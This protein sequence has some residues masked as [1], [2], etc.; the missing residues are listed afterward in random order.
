MPREFFEQ[1]TVTVARKLLGAYLVHDSPE[2]KTAGRIVETEAYLRNDPACHASKGRTPRNAPM[3]GKPG[4]AYV[5]LIYGMYHCFNVVSAPEGIGEAVLIRAL[6][7][8]E[9]L[10]LMAERRGCAVGRN[11]CGGPGRLAQAMDLTPVC[12]GESLRRGD[13]RLYGF[14]SFTGREALSLGPVV[15]TTRIGI[16]RGADLPLR[17]YL[18]DSPFVSRR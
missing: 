3:F 14:E 1:D 17:F 18:A 8:L 13:L 10:D 12:N 6:E 2:G 15:T 9:G 16:T 4:T 11:L 5:Y 7:P